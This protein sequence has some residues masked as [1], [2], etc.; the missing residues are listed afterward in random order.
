MK[1]IIED[2]YRPMLSERGFSPNPGNQRY[3]RAGLC[4]KLSEDMGEGYYWIYGQKNLFDI[5]IHDFYFHEDSFMEFDLPE[6]LNITQFESISGEELS[7]YRRLTAGCIKSII[8]GYTPYKILIHKKIPICSIGIEIMPAY[9]E[10]YL[11]KQYPGEYLNPHDAFAHVGQT[12]NFPEMARLLSQ[13]KNYRGEGISA[14]LFYEAK[15]A[16][17]VSLVVERQKKCAFKQEVKLSLQDVKQIET[18]TSYINDHFAFDLPLIRLS[19]IAC[20]GTTKLKS[21]FKQFHGYT[22]TEYIQQRRMS[23]AEHLLSSTN[24]TIGQIA[25]TVGYVS[26][27]RFAELF[28]LST[29]LLPGEYRKMALR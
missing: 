13:V 10:D 24:L 1:D 28:R 12:T 27:S 8:G 29:G 7:P 4:W 17:A 19:R 25:Q 6:C 21:C 26:A 15:V 5:K 20:M 23:Q 2:I 3:G 9:Y 18:V 11:K 16:E 22:I 14:R